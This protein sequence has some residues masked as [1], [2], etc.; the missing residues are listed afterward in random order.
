MGSAN[1]IREIAS[2]FSAQMVICDKHRKRANEIASMVVIGDVA[3]KDIILIDDICDT[4]GTRW[5][6]H[7]VC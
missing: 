6:K 2:Y 7:S 1:R 5:Q 3:D 4:G